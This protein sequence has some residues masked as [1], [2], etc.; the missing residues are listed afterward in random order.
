MEKFESLCLPF[1]SKNNSNIAHF[2][3]PPSVTF[4]FS[5]KWLTE[6]SKPFMI[7]EGDCISWVFDTPLK[8]ALLV[9]C[10]VKMDDISWLPCLLPLS[11]TSVIV[12]TG[13]LLMGFGLTQI[14]ESN[15]V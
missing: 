4:P 5:F 3:V 7:G 1:G 12:T 10:S 9:F 8:I 11:Y 6:L 2:P 13:L 15:F 14:L